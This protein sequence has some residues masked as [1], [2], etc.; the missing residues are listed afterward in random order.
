MEEQTMNLNFAKA[1]PY[2]LGLCALLIIAG[3]ICS[4]SG[5]GS[6][7][8]GIITAEPTPMSVELNGGNGAIL[9]HDNV[10]T[11]NV[12]LLSPDIDLDNCLGNCKV[13]NVNG[14]STTGNVTLDFRDQIGVGAADNQVTG[15]GESQ[16]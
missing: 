2:L 8:G 6:I 13:V 5:I 11:N 9:R 1:L 7:L 4:I 16:K 3:I 14:I 12:K 15:N 10:K